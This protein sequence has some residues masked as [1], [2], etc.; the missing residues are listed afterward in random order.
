MTSQHAGSMQKCADAIIC[1]NKELAEF[2]LPPVSR[3]LGILKYH[4]SIQLPVYYPT[5]TTH[6][7]PVVLAIMESTPSVTGKVMLGIDDGPSEVSVLGHRF[8]APGFPTGVR[9]IH[10]STESTAELV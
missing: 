1:M 8:P 10:H 2:P 7:L 4:H 5:G 9:W 3:A 6:S